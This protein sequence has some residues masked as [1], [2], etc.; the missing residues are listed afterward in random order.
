MARAAAALATLCVVLAAAA[1]ARANDA[2]YSGCSGAPAAVGAGSACVPEQRQDVELV[3]EALSIREILE[4]GKARWQV[5][6]R[7]RFV[8]RGADV[9]LLV[10]FPIDDPLSE[11]GKG[12][13]GYEVRLDGVTAPWR[14]FV[15]GKDG[16]DAAQAAARLFRYDRVHLTEVAFPAGATRELVHRYTQRAS[17]NNQ[18]MAWHR[19]ILRTGAH[20]RGGRIGHIT[21][22]IAHARPVA[23]DHHAVSLRGARWDA[24][25]RTLQW[26]ATAWEP[27]RDLHY[28][29][30]VPEAIAWELGDLSRFDEGEPLGALPNKDLASALRVV[31]QVY[32]DPR[33]PAKRVY[34]SRG[35]MLRETWPARGALRPIPPAVDP[36]LTLA[37]MDPRVRAALLVLDRELT[38]R[39]ARHLSLP[40]PR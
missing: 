12:V 23:Y 32:R 14:P 13:D 8:N 33:L 31:L 26:E 3:D 19:Y 36:G 37:S 39:K 6:A 16:D 35:Q 18:W 29:W 4:G 24:R 40:M 21:I 25:A 20:W 30:G 9:T 11:D 7:Y 22:T 28:V 2:S 34:D 10:G 5:E 15:V 1:P 17:N 38:T 27:K